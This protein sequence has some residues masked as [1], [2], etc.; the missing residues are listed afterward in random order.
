M[1]ILVLKVNVVQLALKDYK[2]LL[3]LKVKLV[4]R[5]P[6]VNKAL[7]V[8]QD[9]QVYRGKRDK[10]ASKGC[11][12]KLVLRGLKVNGVKRVNLELMASKVPQVMMV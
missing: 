3:V 6:V 1:V 9:I 7:K 8:Q 10:M 2:G 11:K 4:R 12:V 5:V